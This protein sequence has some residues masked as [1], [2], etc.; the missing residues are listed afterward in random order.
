MEGVDKETGEREFFAG[1]PAKPIWR[2]PSKK[3]RVSRLLNFDFFN[4]SGENDQLVVNSN[5]AQND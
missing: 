3:Q 4:Q 1:L 2:Q 5:L